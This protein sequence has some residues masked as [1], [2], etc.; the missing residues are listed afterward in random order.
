MHADEVNIDAALVRRLLVAQFPRWAGLSIEPVP[1]FG[2]DNAIYRLGDEMVVRLPRSERSSPT[3]KKEL[4]LLP[5]LGPLLP[6]AIPEP[7]AEGTPGEGY[8]FPWAVYTWLK[9][10]NAT[11]NHVT[12][13]HQLAIGLAR[14]LAA[15]QRVDPTGGPSPGIHNFFRGVPLRARD[16]MTRTAI[17]SLGRSIDTSAVTAVWEA[18]LEA[19]EWLHPPVW[20]HGDLDSRN[21]LVERGRLC[22]VIDFGGLGIG[23]PACDVM[24]AWKLFPSD[25]RDIFRT[26]LSVDEATWTR[27]Q[28]WALSQA[29]LALSYYT[30]ET[31]PELVLE[32]RRWMKE[33]LAE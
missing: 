22:A 2:T 16:E 20:I 32:A 24:V 12:D 4:R 8:P 33:I 23:D 1:H 29:L 25:T 11:V 6:I 9:G 27:S 21:L 10:E 14:F 3:L 13:F 18:A 19:T 26:E 5:R 30:E 15:L 17:S 31:N 7:K 28:G